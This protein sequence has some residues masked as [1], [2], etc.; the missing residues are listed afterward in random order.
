MKALDVVKAVTRMT[1]AAQLLLSEGYQV[2][3]LM[4]TY[5][6][7]DQIAWL[8]IAKEK[9]N[10]EDLISWVDKYMLGPNPMECT[11]RE[12][13]EARNGLLHMGTAESV[14]IQNDPS[15]RKIYYTF[16]QATC[17]RNSSTDTV[18]VHADELVMRFLNGAIWFLED[19]KKD[20]A[21]EA[22]ALEKLGRTLTSRGLTPEA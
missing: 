18:I 7:I 5:A 15:I 4:L 9:S 10:R 14:A 17:T 1:E 8:S 2:P 13:W 19:L 3:A 11:A 6:G 12:L 20:Q 21:M 22:I 16:G